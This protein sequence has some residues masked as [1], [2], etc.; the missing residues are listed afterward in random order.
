MG[1]CDLERLLAGIPSDAEPRL[2]TS[3]HAGEDAGVYLMEDGSAL[4][5]TVDFFP[6]SWTTPT[7]SAR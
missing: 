7:T 6:R 1:P 2:L 5:L 3:L 4:V